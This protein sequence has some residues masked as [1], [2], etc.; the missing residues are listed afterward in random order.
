MP[1]EWLELVAIAG[2]ATRHGRRSK[3]TLATP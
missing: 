1:P 3:V 2:G